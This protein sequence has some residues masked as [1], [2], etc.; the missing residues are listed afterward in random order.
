[1]P[2]IPKYKSLIARKSIVGL[3][4]RHAL[5]VIGLLID[6]S[7]SA[8]RAG[9]ITKALTWC[10][11]IEKRKLKPVDQAELEYFRANAW[12]KRRPRYNKR[13]STA[14][15]WEQPALQQE[16]L[17]LR[18]AR[19]G[20][21]FDKLHRIRQCQI[22]TNLA[23]Q[24]S[25]TG[26]IV[27]AIELWS[28]ALALEPKFWMARGNRGSGLLRYARYLYS[29]T[30]AAV[31][32]L[33]SHED[34]SQAISDAASHSHFGFAE[35]RQYFEREKQW[36]DERI[37]IN[38]ISK[39]FSPQ[40]GDLGNSEA[41]RRYRR[42]CLTNR[43][44]LSPTN[45]AYVQA[46]AADDGLALPDFVAPIRQPPVLIGFFNQLKQ[47][48]VSSRWLYYAGTHNERPHFSDR[49][50][51]LFNTLDYPVYGLAA[52]QVRAA[53][54][55]AYSLL[56]K[57]AFFLNAYFKLGI[58][59]EQVS[60]NRVWRDKT[61]KKGTVLPRF[62]RSKNLPLRG[63]Y[64]LSKDLFDAELKEVTSPDAF[65]LSLIRNHL[66]HR[67]LK[68]L[69]L[70]PRKA[71]MQHRRRYDGFVDTMAYSV[72][73]SSFEE[74]VLRLLKLSRSA[75]FYLTLAMHQEELRRQRARRKVPLTIGQ[76]LPVIEHRWK[77]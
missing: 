62:E 71:G 28:E 68:V 2:T 24:L 36:L 72:S 11:D 19:N 54:R 14:W 22:L 77:K 69:D 45:D 9:G 57:V 39:K 20:G 73:R 31:L 58:P 64:W 44:F 51:T 37:D 25:T 47:E 40:R 59:L 15:K 7:D 61:G 70:L 6:A 26:Q 38:G 56:D 27:E 18:R 75:L 10:D 30:H 33:R 63:L 5:Q 43:L 21:G 74:K 13:S 65:E 32:F 50:V 17:A 42:W 41:E 34:L 46:A 12:D 49:N 76:S 8:R 66:E 3:S 48:Y 55:I 29:P 60:F 35:A 67:Y 4:T 23:N 52:E 1:M 53:Y 16:I